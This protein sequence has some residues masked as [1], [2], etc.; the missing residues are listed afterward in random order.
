MTGY[1]ITYSNDFGK[2]FLGVG[3]NTLFF[4]RSSAENAFTSSSTTLEGDIDTVPSV[5]RSTFPVG[6]GACKLPGIRE[7]SIRHVKVYLSEN[8]YLFLPLPWNPSQPEFEVFLQQINTIHLN[9]PLIQYEAEN[10]D[11]EWAVIVSK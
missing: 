10:I 9:A 4:S 8:Q 11:G 2:E 7:S 3:V 6:R 5:F 1:T